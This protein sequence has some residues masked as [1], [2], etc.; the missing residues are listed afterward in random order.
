M[1]AMTWIRSIRGCSSRGW[2][3]TILAIFQREITHDLREVT[4]IGVFTSLFG[5]FSIVQ[6]SLLP[7][8]LGRLKASNG[9]GRGF[10][11]SGFWIC[12]L[13]LKEWGLLIRY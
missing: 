3:S 1:T 8:K 13:D 4:A 6:S 9:R 10:I 2:V 7:P 11:A 5:H 12:W